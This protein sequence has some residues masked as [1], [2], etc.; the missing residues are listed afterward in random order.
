MN[1]NKQ[2]LPWTYVEGFLVIFG[3]GMVGIGI[4]VIIQWFVITPAGM[5]PGGTLL[6]FS[7]PAIGILLLQ[8]CKK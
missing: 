5:M 7:I 6:T 1:E 4:I 2:K 8:I 3:W